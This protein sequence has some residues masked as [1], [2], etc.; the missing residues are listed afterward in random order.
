MKMMT[1]TIDA[2]I[3]NGTLTGTKS[4]DLCRFDAIPYAEAPVGD[5]RF[6]PP[7]AARWQG[8]LDATR[9]GPVPPQL[10][11]RLRKAMGDFDAEQAEDCLQLTVWTP[12]VDEKR[13]P[14]V[15]WLHG[16][17]WQSGGGALAW[18]DGTQLAE[19]G[20]LVVVGVNYRL[21]ALGWLYLPEQGSNLGLLDQE[22]ALAWVADHIASFGGD[23]S[24]ITVMGQSAGGSNI[25]AMLARQPRFHRAI[26]QSASLGRGFRTIEQARRLSA[27]FLEAIGAKDVDDARKVA[28]DALLQAQQAPGV[29]EAL[30][31]EGT[32]RSLF[33]PVLDGV[34]LPVDIDP[35]LTAA[36]GKVDVLIGYTH[37]EMA[38]FPGMSTDDASQAVGERIFGTPARAWA[39]QAI[40]QGRQAWGYRFDLAP[41]E[42][43]GACHC[44]ELPF[45]FGTL[46]AFDGA[47]MLAGL[48][49]DHARRLSDEMQRAW[50]AFIHGDA[51]PWALAPHFEHFA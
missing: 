45:V 47:P 16:G 27:A 42:T 4:N 2:V 40:A 36:T 3:R 35:A 21:A 1:E 41:T 31:A 46:R 11:S 18:Y 13:R 29:V 23:P 50:I 38:A 14:V 7:V 30:A 17:A 39:E 26:M 22:L 48:A 15:V 12:G 8:T 9:P 19:R 43:L 28:V 34:V 20:D 25:A 6:K 49:H 37:N 32:G 44:I 24:R 10:P 5:L 33:C 51:P